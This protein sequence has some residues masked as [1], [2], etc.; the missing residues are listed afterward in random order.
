MCIRDSYHSRPVAFWSLSAFEQLQ[1]PHY[2]R[3]IRRLSGV[4]SGTTLRRASV[5]LS[6]PSDATC[7]ARPVGQ[8][9]CGRRLPQPGQLTI[10]EELLGYHNN[11]NIKI[12]SLIL[13]YICFV[14]ESSVISKIR[15]KHYIVVK[16]DDNL[17]QSLS[18]SYSLRCLRLLLKATCRRVYC[19]TRWSSSVDS[20][21]LKFVSG[22]FGRHSE[23]CGESTFLKQVRFCLL[24]TYTISEFLQRDSLCNAL[25]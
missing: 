2:Q 15:L 24:F 13:F 11:N 3:H 18:L 20:L 8:P 5:Q 4:W 7:S 14:I 17:D 21:C 19:R 9:G 25:V 23:W 6:K 10:G 1:S 12:Y 22:S 16:A